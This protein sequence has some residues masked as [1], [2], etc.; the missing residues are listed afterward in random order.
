M[1][2]ISQRSLAGG[3]ITPALYA[4]VDQVKYATGVKTCR[5]FIVLRHGGVANRPGGGFV[6]EVENSAELVKLIEFVFNTE[7]TYIL[8]F[9]ALTGAGT[10]TPSLNVLKDECDSSAP[11]LGYTVPYAIGNFIL[12]IWGTVIINF[13]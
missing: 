12:T 8:L 5:N 10:A 3:E 13:M 11:A 6:C 2:T 1:T 7:Q 4:R 9:G